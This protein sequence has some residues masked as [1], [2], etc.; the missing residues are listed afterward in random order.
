MNN[1]KHKA[2]A[3]FRFSN[4]SEP[5][6]ASE[7]AP[8]EVKAYLQRALP[9]LAKHE[10][11]DL[12]H[13]IRQFYITKFHRR[14][15]P[16][17]GTINKG[18]TEEQLQRFFRAIE[19]PKFRLLFS[20]QANLGLRIGEVIKV[21]VKD[22]DFETRE[23]VIRTEKTRLLDSL[24]IPIP[25][26]KE[27]VEFANANSDN[28]ERNKGY[29][30]FRDQTKSQRAEPYLEPNY[31]RNRFRHYLELAGLDE[32]YDT[33]DEQQGRSP[34]RLHRLTTHSLRHYAITR[35]A[36]NANGN[37]I[38]TSRFARHVDPST[39]SIYIST[40]K[41]EVYDVI[42]SMAV[43]EVARLKQRVGK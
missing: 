35:F 22:I 24:K 8:K 10:V 29:I 27:L 6:S 15:T 18:F 12:T 1:N 5:F 3:G 14:R 33:S 20:F 32:V 42:D 19:D 26:F 7:T 41:Q 34:R 30:F 4:K 25:L 39:T 31:V 38:L 9:T 17:Y 37:L 36:K 21:N 2:R 16:K 28:I 23:I 40:S 13:T 11:E 43:S